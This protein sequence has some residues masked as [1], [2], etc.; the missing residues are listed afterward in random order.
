MAY[1]YYCYRIILLPILLVQRSPLVFVNQQHNI[2]TFG[3]DLNLQCSVDIPSSPTINYTWFR[4]DQELPGS[5]VN[6][7]GSL[8]VPNI[9]EGEYASREGVDYYCIARDNFGFDVAI[10][11]RTIT[12]YYACESNQ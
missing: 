11:S 10:R 5:L 4:G 9:T 2:Y 7:E 1:S 8:I 3:S 6:G 12:V